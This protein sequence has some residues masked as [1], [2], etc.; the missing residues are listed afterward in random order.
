MYNT[1][2]SFLLYYM[3]VCTEVMSFITCH[4][5]HCPAVVL[6]WIGRQ[7]VSQS[8]SQAGRQ[9]GIV[10]F[11][12]LQILPLGQLCYVS[13]HSMSFHM[14]ISWLSTKSVCMKNTRSCQGRCVY[15]AWFSRCTLTV[16]QWT[17]LLIDS[18]LLRT[19]CHWPLLRVISHGMVL[20]F[21]VSKYAV[22][23]SF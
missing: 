21:W 1:K 10:A 12:T 14:T 5:A 4:N 2:F 13:K 16:V 8:V 17:R 9:A 7:S 15:Q 22:C 20:L 23:F 19:F 11:I 6:H 18:C 3:A